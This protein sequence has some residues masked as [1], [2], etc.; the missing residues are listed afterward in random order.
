MSIPDQSWMRLRVLSVS[1]TE[2]ENRHHRD[3]REGT[4]DLGTVDQ[5]L[6]G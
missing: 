5:A 6:I 1:G 2:T 4:Q 3:P